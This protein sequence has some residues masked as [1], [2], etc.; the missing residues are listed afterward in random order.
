M[1]HALHRR[2]LFQTLRNIA[3][4]KEKWKVDNAVVILDET[5][6][7]R[8]WY[9]ALKYAVDIGMF[10]NDVIYVSGSVSMYAKKEVETFPA[11][12]YTHL[13]LPTKR[14]V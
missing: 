12:S 4:L 11:V 7:P 14:I 13:T 5:T 8:E 3:D 10:R 1:R 9:R 2:E 6:Y